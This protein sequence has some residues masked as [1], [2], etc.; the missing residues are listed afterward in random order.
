[1]ENFDDELRQDAEAK[2]GHADALQ[3]GSAGLPNRAAPDHA[4]TEPV[5][6]GI[7]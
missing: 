4:G 7:T 5:N 2:G 3:C 6:N 1:L